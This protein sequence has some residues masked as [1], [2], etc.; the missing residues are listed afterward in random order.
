MSWCA[1][2]ASGELLR[3]HYAELAR[4]AYTSAMAAFAPALTPMLA[5]PPARVFAATNMLVCVLLLLH[6]C[7]EL[8][9]PLCSGRSGRL[10]SCR[11]TGAGH[12]NGDCG[13]SVGHLGELWVM[14]WPPDSHGVGNIFMG[15]GKPFC[16]PSAGAHYCMFRLRLQEEL[17]AGCRGQRNH[18]DEVCSQSSAGGHDD[19]GILARELRPSAHSP[20][21]I[22]LSWCLLAPHINS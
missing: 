22:R 8:L 16:S 18:V 14:V 3:A 7:S 9:F 21:L 11:A 1:G 13:G 5:T 2:W 20:S 4:L 6:F 19:W 12:R 17:A 15:Q 10:R